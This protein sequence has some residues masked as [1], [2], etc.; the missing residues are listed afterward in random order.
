MNSPANSQA[1]GQY[2][3]TT[4]M[5]KTYVD[6]LQVNLRLNISVNSIKSKTHINKDI[7]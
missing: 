2:Y 3:S 5:I 6:W 1:T 4:P 7:P